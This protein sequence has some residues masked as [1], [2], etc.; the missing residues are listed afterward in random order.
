MT[1]RIL[2]LLQELDW[3]TRVRRVKHR[4]HWR[5]YLFATLGTLFAYPVWEILFPNTLWFYRLWGAGATGGIVGSLVGFTWQLAD[6][7]RR[8]RSS[9]RYLAFSVVFGLG[10]LTPIGVFLMGPM[11]RS[12]E[13]ELAKIRALSAPEVAAISFRMS[14]QPD[15][16]FTDRASI[17]SFVNDC[18]RS[19]LFYPSHERFT[20]KSRLA[21]YFVDG[22]VWYDAG[23]PERHR[24]DM[25][26]SFRSY[27]GRSYILIPNGA[28][29]LRVNAGTE[30]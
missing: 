16:K 18:R 10:V 20:N 29:W 6:A 23:I 26:L 27:I 8:A 17:I 21:V 28:R 1:R 24:A 22:T 3:E 13:I 2:R 19:N 25:V 7:A 4:D 14:G 30:L 12:E 11:L 9:G 5:V 15:V